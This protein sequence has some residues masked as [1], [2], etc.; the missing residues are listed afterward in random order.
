[1]LYQLHNEIILYF[2]NE[3]GERFGGAQVP[4]R[5]YLDNLI[6]FSIT[7]SLLTVVSVSQLCLPT[8]MSLVY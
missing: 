1:M 2:Y 8:V 7:I 5:V 6:E 4:V 3:I